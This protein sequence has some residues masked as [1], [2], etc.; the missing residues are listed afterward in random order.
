[1]NRSGRSYSSAY[2]RPSA[3]NFLWTSS[4]SSISDF[5]VAYCATGCALNTS[6]GGLSKADDSSCKEFSVSTTYLRA[7]DYDPEASPITND[8]Q[9]APLEHTLR[10]I[11]HVAAQGG[12]PRV[13]ATKLAYIKL[14]ERADDLRTFPTFS[15]LP[16]VVRMRIYGLAMQ[17]NAAT[18]GMDAVP[19]P[20]ISMVS[21]L[22]RYETLPLF[23]QN[24][25]IGV[26]LRH[27]GP[28]PQL[29]NGGFIMDQRIARYLASQAR[30]S[31]MR[32]N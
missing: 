16:A 24:Q 18:E 4:T 27:Q 29:P 5:S 1:M 20:P 12:R 15:A 2:G 7:Y 21:R 32:A 6:S 28:T 23:Y 14:L 25:K 17:P 9:R 31:L 30:E 22:L 3:A 11:E 26:Q 13:S 8:Q 19:Q 10:Y